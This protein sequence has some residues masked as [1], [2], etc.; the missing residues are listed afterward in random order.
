MF[1][2]TFTAKR[3]NAKRHIITK[4]A[5]FEEAYHFYNMM[6]DPRYIFE[7]CNGRWE[8]VEKKGGEH[9]V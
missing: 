4:Y 7:I 9:N 1:Y 5:T 2:V 8:T 3:K 6:Y